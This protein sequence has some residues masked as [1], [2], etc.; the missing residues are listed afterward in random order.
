MNWLGLTRLGVLDL[1]E[2]EVTLV[3]SMVEALSVLV[4]TLDV[5]EAAISIDGATGLN[6]VAGK[7]VV[8]NKVLS[9]LVHVDSVG[10]LLSAE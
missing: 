10:K 1:S 9:W 7:V 3:C 5:E 8:S 4:D 2:V 6:F